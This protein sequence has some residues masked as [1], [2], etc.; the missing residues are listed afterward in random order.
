MYIFNYYSWKITKKKKILEV[1]RLKK[2]DYKMGFRKFAPLLTVHVATFARTFFVNN[3]I[4]TYKKGYNIS[5]ISFKL[6]VVLPMSKN[7]PN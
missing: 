5:N 4:K 7:N 6:D 2:N 3:L 1:T